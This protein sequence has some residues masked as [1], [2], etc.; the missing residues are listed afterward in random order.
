MVSEEE[1]KFI[2]IR[3]KRFI[4]LYEFLKMDL[5]MT[6][7]LSEKYERDFIDK[8]L[9]PDLTNIE[10]LNDLDDNNN[11]CNVQG[12]F[13]GGCNKKPKKGGGMKVDNMKINGKDINQECSNEEKNDDIEK[14]IEKDLDSCKT[15]GKNKILKKLYHKISKIV[16]PDKCDDKTK[17]KMFI[18]AKDYYDKDILIGLLNICT[19]LK[20]DIDLSEIGKEEFVIIY[21]NVKQLEANI[22]RIKENVSWKWSNAANDN[23]KSKIK[24]WI[25][26]KI[27]NYFIKN[28]K[29]YINNLYPLTEY[30]E[31]EQTRN[32]IHSYLYPVCTLCSNVYKRKNKIARIKKCNHEYH[33]NCLNKWTDENNQYKCPTCIGAI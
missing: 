5:E 20:I 15:K 29:F 24:L 9:P 28:I 16:H 18:D 26:K 8:V 30:I 11:S 21:T 31:D 3:V 22:K 7:I 1:N 10:D 2:I 17:N 32:I 4:K 12:Q 27:N 25:Q 19:I 6:Q 23:E 13:G 33:L 14:D